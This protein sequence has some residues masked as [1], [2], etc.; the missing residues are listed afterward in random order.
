MKK[1]SELPLVVDPAVDA[2]EGETS[3]RTQTY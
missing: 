2:A 3:V 1:V